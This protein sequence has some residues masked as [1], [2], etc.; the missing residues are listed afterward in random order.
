MLYDLELACPIASFASLLPAESNAAE[1]VNRI[2]VAAL[3]G[4]GDWARRLVLEPID[5]H[6]ETDPIWAGVAYYANQ[7]DVIVAHRA[8]FD[9]Q[10]VTAQAR[11]AAPWVC[12]KTEIDWPLGEPGSSLI[13]LALAHGVGVV[14]AHRAMADVDILARLLTRVAE[15][16]PH[17]PAWFPASA[18]GREAHQPILVRMLAQA[19]RPRVRVVSLAPFSQKDHVKAAGFLWDADKKVW[20]KRV[21][22]EDI[23]GLGFKV[24]EE[25]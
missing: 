8:E 4:M 10:F 20:W 7:A 15:I 24:K 12:S 9:R 18:E 16:G 5:L 3:R 21:V 14:S 19:M 23:P 11:K 2:P 17:L 1:A 22:R 25:P 13:N 6:D